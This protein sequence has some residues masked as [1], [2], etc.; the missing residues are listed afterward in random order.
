M[1]NLMTKMK[2]MKTINRYISFIV[3]QTHIEDHLNQNKARRQNYKPETM[4]NIDGNQYIFYL[5]LYQ[6]VLIV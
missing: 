1:K 4:G 5:I 3:V 6:I 2:M